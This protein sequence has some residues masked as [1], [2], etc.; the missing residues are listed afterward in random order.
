MVRL[1]HD[2]LTYSHFS[3]GTREVAE[4]DLNQQ[5]KDVLEDPELEIAEKGVEIFVETLAKIRGNSRQFHQL[6]QNL[7][8]NA[9]KYTRSHIVPKIQIS[10]QEVVGCEAN[11][12]LAT[13]E[14]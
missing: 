4:I 1:I 8:G 7:I 9:I 14:G 13:E 10:S 12:N 5:V 11:A 3:K 6:L 2:L